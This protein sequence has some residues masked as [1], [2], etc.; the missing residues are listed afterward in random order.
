MKVKSLVTSLELMELDMIFM[1]VIG[2][3]YIKQ[4]D[5]SGTKQKRRNKI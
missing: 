5:C 3:H 4:E 1:K 2:F